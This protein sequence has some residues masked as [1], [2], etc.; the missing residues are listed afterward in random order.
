MLP[1][2]LTI[3]KINAR[4]RFGSSS[5]KKEEMIKRIIDAKSSTK[6]ALLS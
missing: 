1:K 3:T 6:V 5:K 2:D 4:L